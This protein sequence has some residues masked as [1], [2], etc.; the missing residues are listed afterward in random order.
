L[1]EEDSA[2]WFSAGI[3]QTADQ[4]GVAARQARKMVENRDEVTRGVRF[5]RVRAQLLK[6]LSETESIRVNAINVVR[7]YGP[8]A[9]RLIGSDKPVVFNEHFFEVMRKSAA[10]ELHELRAALKRNFNIEFSDAEVRELKKYYNKVDDFSPGVWVEKRTLANLDNAKAGGFSA[11]FKGMGAKNLEQVAKD[12][13]NNPNDLD[14]AL[15][16]IREGEKSVTE[17]FNQNKQNYRE[18]VEGT[19]K[20]FN[21]KVDQACSGDDCVSM[22]ASPLTQE[23]EREIVQAFS[24]SEQA[25]NLRLSFI[26]PNVLGPQR[27][28]LAVHGEMIE[29]KIRASIIGFGDYEIAPE[30]LKRLNF[31]IKMPVQIR[32]GSV[33]LILGKSDDFELTDDQADLIKKGF[34]KAVRQVNRE[35][36]GTGEYSVPIN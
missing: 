18:T 2:R 25:S 24:K 21:I 8:Q 11:D 15:E 17:I 6:A 9:F 32:R 23:M 5:T 10:G 30:V 19:L 7:K 26:P 1:S 16:A 13:A 34:Q 31:A 35:I 27:S 22:V 14:E 4:A 28:E 12:L 3:G 33:E 29:K 36:E 20:R